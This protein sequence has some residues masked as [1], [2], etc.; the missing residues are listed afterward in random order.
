MNLSSVK[1]GYWERFE[2]MAKNPKE[3]NL[4]ISEFL[5]LS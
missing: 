2:P 1:W 4:K 5:I 3:Q